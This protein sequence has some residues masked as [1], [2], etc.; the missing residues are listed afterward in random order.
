M[1]SDL[2]FRSGGFFCLFFVLHDGGEKG[3]KIRLDPLL[4][5]HTI[6]QVQLY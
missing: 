3:L 2:Y 4:T 5:Y 6:N 1:L